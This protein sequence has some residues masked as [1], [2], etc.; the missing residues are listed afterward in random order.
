[1]SYRVKEGEQQGRSTTLATGNA[2]YHTECSILLLG[3]DGLA[4]GLGDLMEFVL[5]E[6]MC[7]RGSS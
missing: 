6:G 5:I 4:V 2:V 3:M 7:H 1:M